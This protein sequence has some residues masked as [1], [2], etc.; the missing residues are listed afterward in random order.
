MA[1]RDPRVAL[2]VVGDGPERSRVEEAVVR[3]GAQDHVALLGW[4]KHDEL[5][6]YYRHAAVGLL[7]FLDGSHVRI[8]LANKLFDYMGAGLPVVATDLASTRRILQETGAGFSPVQEIP[9]ISPG[10]SA[11]CWPIRPEQRQMSEN[12]RRAV[13][14]RY[15]WKHDA[16]RLLE[17]LNRLQ[18]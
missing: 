18:P 17:A 8:T 16:E 2:I 5:A 7:P 15:S 12:G 13:A 3:L 14:L 11:K 10:P 1:E 6:A 9:P 4:K